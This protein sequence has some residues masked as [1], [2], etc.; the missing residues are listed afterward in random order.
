[1]SIARALAVLGA[2]MQGLG[3]G[4]E[5]NRQRRRQEEDDAF[6]K[7]QRDRQRTQWQ[8]DDEAY[9][10]AKADKAA[11]RQAMAPT[12]VQPDLAPDQMGPAGFNAGGKTFGAPEQADAAAKQYNAL[13]AGMRRAAGAVRN[14][15]RAAELQGKADQTELGAMN[16]DAAKQ[17]QEAQRWDRSLYEAA[18][19]ADPKALTDFMTAS[20]A[21][22]LDGNSKWAHKVDGAN[23]SIYPVGP[24]GTALSQGFT[25]PNTPAGRLELVAQLSR[26]TP[27]TA[28]LADLRAQQKAT[29]DAEDKKADNAR[30][31]RAQAATERYQ[32]GMLG[33]HQAEL[34]IKRDAANARAAGG[35]GGA[36]A[37]DAAPVWDDK[38]STFLR[39]KFTITDPTTGATAVD[40]AGL[41]F[42]KA[43]SLA[44]ARRNGGDLDSA[45][46]GAFDIDARLRAA[47]TDPKG[48]Y[49][50]GK[51]NALRAQ[52]LQSLSAPRAAQSGPQPAAPA[53]TPTPAPA[54]VPQPRAGMAAAAAPAEAVI[55]KPP[56]TFNAVPEMEQALAKEMLEMAEGKRMKFSTPELAAYGKARKAAADA[57]QQPGGMSELQ[58]AQ[59][60]SRQ[61]LGKV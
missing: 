36:G 56:T 4:E 5:T 6:R 7:E 24:D 46:G 2:G 57:A 21:D 9:N 19:A 32:Q 50:A 10:E 3:Q 39:Q 58:R 27:I 48:G 55:G 54:A 23:L 60:L 47:A 53:P 33:V 51:H 35:A 30:A 49:D 26:A 29:A 43:M 14:P 25:I 61:Q 13:A 45:I 16:L 20:K 44:F 42:G 28:K 11:E 8:R 34:G 40:G 12:V 38:A 22:G 17:A 1:M 37:A 15:T 59:L 18:R 52:A 41:Q 31:D